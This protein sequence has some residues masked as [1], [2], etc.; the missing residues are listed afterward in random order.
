MPTVSVI[1][2]E[3]R[4]AV[5]GDLQTVSSLE[6]LCFKDPYPPY[7]ISQLAEANPE[8]F[9]VAEVNGHLVGYVVADRWMDH[10]HLVSIA[11]H[12]KERMKGIGERLL[13]ALEARLG[14][15]RPIRLEVRKNNLPALEMYRKHGFEETALIPGYYAD[16][17]DAIVMEKTQA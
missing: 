1:E 5:P 17:E 3:I 10:D 15:T 16:G 4:S 6:D 14:R 12:P 13:L 11:V 2:I 7:F 9:L 8:T